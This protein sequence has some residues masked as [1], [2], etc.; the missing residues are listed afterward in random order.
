PQHLRRDTLQCRGADGGPGRR[1]R[2]PRRAKS[3]RP[4]AGSSSGMVSADPPRCAA[5]SS[6]RPTPDQPP[7]TTTIRPRVTHAAPRRRP[8][9]PKVACGVL[10]GLIANSLF[11][12]W[13]LDPVVALG[14]SAVAVKEG[15][16]A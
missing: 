5:P 6:R 9:P 13:W 1:C 15:R 8:A 11:G 7:R 3:R 2:R 16:D 10:T 14:I 12:W 4:R